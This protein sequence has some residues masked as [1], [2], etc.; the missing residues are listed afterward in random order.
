MKAQSK[1]VHR[2]RIQRVEVEFENPREAFKTKD[3]LSEVCRRRLIPAMEKML[4]RKYAAGSLISVPHL[5]IDAGRLSAENWEE[6]FVDAVVE[7]LERS[8]DETSRER[9]FS[10]DGTDRAAGF[11]LHYLEKGRLP[12][13]SP[14]ENT[15]QLRE[16]LLDLLNQ[17]SK[18]SDFLVRIEASPN[19]GKNLSGQARLAVDF[20]TALREL[21]VFNSNALKRFLY[22][23]PEDRLLPVLY[24]K[25][26]SRREIAGIRKNWNAIFN[27]AGLPASDCDIVFLQALGMLGGKGRET[28]PGQL[29]EELSGEIVRVLEQRYHQVFRKL[30][31]VLENYLNLLPDA[32]I[33]SSR[34]TRLSIPAAE[35]SPVQLTEDP[36]YINNAGLVLLHPFLSDLFENTGHTVKNKW[37]S[38]E[39]RQRS[40]LLSQYL[41]SGGD[42]YTEQD[43]FLNKI[44]TGLPPDEPFPLDLQ[45][46]EF[47]K[48]EADDLLESV[49]MHWSAL[50]NT[51]P[52][53]LRATFLQRVG[54]IEKK[55]NAWL[56]KVNPEVAD[57][58]LNKIPW[59]FSIVKTPWMKGILNVEWV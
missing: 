45:L 6:A 50:K 24:R 23:V 55:N 1:Q 12:W 5:L 4:D 35:R 37:D 59:G 19:G 2:I 17:A 26:W 51:S 8:L 21:V 25:D 22:L 58:L 31:N 15:G 30:P 43:I 56:M 57:I 7:R 18:G 44:L 13:N 46:S 52:G 42:N 34:N 54:K 32:N 10:T 47:E 36:V 53:G 11:M 27:L 20:A 49:I 39:L 38:S 28:T 16:L 33:S 48:K 14:Y 9:A 41:V 29:Q 3:Q 40:I